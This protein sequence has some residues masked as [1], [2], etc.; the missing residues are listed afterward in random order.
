[1][2]IVD[3]DPILISGVYTATLAEAVSV[4]RIASLGSPILASLGKLP[5]DSDTLDCKIY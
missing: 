4:S 3:V 2:K 1:M 5:M